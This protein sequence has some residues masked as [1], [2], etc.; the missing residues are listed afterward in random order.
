M[1]QRAAAKAW[2]R[3]FISTPSIQANASRS[4]NTVEV[5]EPPT[6]AQVIDTNL[7]TEA[8]QSYLSYAMSVIV[9]RALPD[10]RDGLKPVHRRILFAMHDLGLAHN[11]P[12]RKC[13]RVVGE[14]LGKYHPHGDTAVYDSLVRMAQPFTLR[15]PLVSG[16]GNFGSLD[17]DPPAAMRY[18]ECRLQG[19]ASAMLLADLGADT[20]DWAPNFDA[21]Q[22]EPVV[23]PAALPN[24]LLNGSSGIA[25]AIATK[26]P[27]HNMQEVVAALKALIKNPAI[28][29]SELMQHVPAPD[30]PT[31]GR[32]IDTGNMRAIYEEGRG[33]ITVRGR[34]FVEEEGTSK[35]GS[36]RTPAASGKASII[37]T[38]MPYQT[39]KSSFV[40]NVAR[41]VNA[42]TL[43]GVADVRDES[44]R[45]GMRVVV[46]LKRNVNA[47]VILANLHKHSGLQASFACN[48][49]ALVDGTPQLLG[50]K[51]ALSH[52][53]SFRC[54]VV[55]RR[56]QYELRRSQKRLHLV[57]GY[58]AALKRLDEVVAT[59][60]AAQD[61]AE[62]GQQLQ[63]SFGLSEEQAE[64]V[65]NLSLRRLTSL[66]S[67]RLEMERDELS[68]R[69]ADLEDLLR[70]RDRVLSLIDSEI[71]ALSKAHGNPR[72]TA[73]TRDEEVVVSEEELTPNK[74]S[75]V[76]I[77]K[78]G[79]IKRMAPELF[80]VQHRGGRGKAGA[81]L[82]DNDSIEEVMHVMD[83]DHI[84]FFTSDGIVRSRRAFQLP[85]GSRTSGG[86]P[87]TQVLPIQ[88]MDAI[89]AML[90]VSD[91]PEDSYLLMLTEGGS[92]KRTPLSLFKDQAL[93]KGLTAI[94]LKS[95]DRL[96]WVGLCTQNSS[97]LVAST[98][99]TMLHFPLAQV[100]STGR[101]STG[102]QSMKL[103]KG[104]RL[105][106][107][108][109]MPGPEDGSSAEPSTSAHPDPSVLEITKGAAGEA[110]GDTSDESSEE[111]EEGG[112][113]EDAGPV[114]AEGPWLLLVTT[115]GLGK[116]VP[117]SGFR[118]QR[119][120][121]RG[122]R[123]ISLNP[124]DTLA[125]VHM[126][127]C[128]PDGCES[129][130]ADENLMIVT[131]NGLISRTKL[132][133]V[134]VYGLQA[135]GLRLLKLGEGDFVQSV[136]PLKATAEV[137]L[138]SAATL[139]S[140]QSYDE[141]DA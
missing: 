117:V 73:V 68:A 132:L 4:S 12:Y 6:T 104:A 83:H 55:E 54:T 111:E 34:A 51:D 131:A 135:K 24:L 140:T 42:G 103:G 105:V 9:G 82:R 123:A 94:K 106:G 65:L 32:I 35:K 96:A 112:D 5:A 75:L 17:D 84:L 128:G 58:L 27:P 127:G 86:T 85:Q 76:V 3:R 25:V 99:G 19:L 71:T 10:V 80:S 61:G 70:K 66:E 72:R 93:K 53:L 124:D 91:F 21:S 108:S 23:L 44:D 115:K 137:P 63:A 89:T 125:A 14:V 113:A 90:P 97:V 8:Q 81:R 40:E 15:S 138:G 33:S 36:K 120:A 136:T 67:Q 109:I 28:S 102:V 46:E 79:Y 101:A 116:R 43:A 122:K 52:W 119:R 1:Q 64:G 48:M 92:I 139:S 20:V 49:V 121:G 74:P 7:V 78:R 13:A 38:E 133:D 37:I 47:Q 22:E 30:F 69:I 45:D 29:T 141:D 95:G 118:Q 57:Q 60:R 100:T 59:I 134:K 2:Q 77:S 39:N 18:T 98:A 126:V 107:M 114:E 110:A 87:I 130:A 88:K 16:H 50:L 62:A 11:K 26:I 129:P 56:A 41:M 31:G